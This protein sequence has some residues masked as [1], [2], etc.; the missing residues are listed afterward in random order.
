MHVYGCSTL[1]PRTTNTY[2]DV[3]N[4]GSCGVHASSHHGR[5]DRPGQRLHMARGTCLG[6]HSGCGCCLCGVIRADGWCL[7]PHCTYLCV[8]MA[9]AST[10]PYIRLS[11]H[12][13]LCK[14]PLL[15]P[16]S[17]LAPPEEVIISMPVREGGPP[18]AT[19]DAVTLCRRA[20]HAVGRRP[21]LPSPTGN[22]M[23]SSFASLTAFHTPEA[24]S[25][26]AWRF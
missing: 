7:H 14:T 16:L 25:S 2:V 21:L 11:Q 5:Y 9:G 3:R 24:G 4:F 8:C 19:V 26:K 20:R 12:C 22:A 13:N 15:H 10:H 6:K 18:D 23:R 1:F 17:A